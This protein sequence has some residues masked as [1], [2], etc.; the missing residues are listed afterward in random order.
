MGNLYPPERS[1]SF[2]TGGLRQ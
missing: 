2:G 1:E